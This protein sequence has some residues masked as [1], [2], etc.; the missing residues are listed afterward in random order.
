MP[1]ITGI[2][3]AELEMWW[4]RNKAA[5]LAAVGEFGAEVREGMCAGF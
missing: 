3:Q 5:L 2:D 4:N 1:R